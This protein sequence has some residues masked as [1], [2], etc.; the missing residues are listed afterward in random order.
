MISDY[1]ARERAL[2]ANRSFIVQA[3]AGSGKTG[4]L[5]YRILVLLATVE[6]P[7]QVLAI[8][9]TRKA[10]SEMRQR[11]IELLMLAE[12]KQVSEDVFEQQ[13]IDLAAQVLAQDK[14]YSWN[15]LNTPNQLQIQTIDAFCGKL[16]GA[17]PWLSRLG[18]KPRTTDNA[19]PHYAAAIEQLL[20][21]LLG[22][23]SDL[24]TDLQSVLLSLDFNYSRARR[25][26]NA[27]LGRRDQWLRHLLRGDLAQMRNKI[28]ASWCEIRDAHLSKLSEMLPSSTILRLC[29]IAVHAASQIELK[30]NVIKSPLAA[31]EIHDTN[32]PLNY[33]KWVA[34]QFLLQTDKG[35]F[36]KR[37]TKHEGCPAGKQPHKV[38]LQELLA[39]FVDDDEL[40][41]AIYQVK[42][43]PDGDFTDQD[44]QQLLALENVLKSLA[45]LLQLRFRSMGECDHSEVTQRANL[46]LEELNNPTDLALRLDYQI[47]HILVDEF[48]DTSYAQLQLLKRLTAG[49]EEATENRSLFLVGD[50]M[51]SIYRFREADVGL[52]LQVADNRS[53]RL[54]DNVEIE[55]LVLTENFRSTSYLVDWFNQTFKQS[56]P[57]QNQVLNGAICYAEATSNKLIDDTKVITR[58]VSD[59]QQEAEAVVLE[60]QQALNDLPSDKKVAVLVRSRSHLK[61]LLPAM[62]NAEISYAAVDIQPLQ[63]AQ[64]IIDVLSLCKAISRLD[65]RISWLALLRGPWCGLTLTQIKQLVPLT[66]MPIWLQLDKLELGALGDHFDYVI[67]LSRFILCTVFHL[68]MF[69]LYLI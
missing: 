36:R 22:E 1:A 51:Q 37:L 40:K 66:D 13:G 10:T 30:S 44:W 55:P 26:F 62:Q 65:D 21:E 56:F 60:I 32:E 14:R 34:L 39:E 41:E 23:P 54:F 45:G 53:T 31:F 12:T 29:D 4:L 68:M 43:L 57:Q 59:K 42:S 7:E 64:A 17:M 19:E 18:D 46:A 6:R 27:M 25:L 2:D 9:F 11:L 61:S 35:D 3:P 33:E 16:A 24:S 52:F 8:T 28:Q 49:W 67:R 63:E 50:P 5:V 47:N 20:N 15:L 38:Q 48:Q 58:L 69:K